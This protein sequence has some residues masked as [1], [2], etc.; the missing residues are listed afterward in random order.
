[1][2]CD[3]GQG[4]VW[5]WDLNK[6]AKLSSPCQQSWAPNPKELVW[7]QYNVPDLTFDE[8]NHKQGALSKEGKSD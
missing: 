4:E 3:T 7:I 2:D 8:L 5:T 6:R 1:M